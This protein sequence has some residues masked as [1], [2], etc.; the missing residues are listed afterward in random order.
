[1]VEPPRTH[2]KELYVP[3]FLCNKVVREGSKRFVAVEPL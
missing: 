2:V 3:G 1:M